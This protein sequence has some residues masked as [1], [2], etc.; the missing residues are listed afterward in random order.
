MEVA[1]A[2][3]LTRASMESEHYHYTMNV[4]YAPYGDSFAAS[5]AG[6]NLINIKKCVLLYVYSFFLSINGATDQYDFLFTIVRK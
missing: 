4:I 1:F 6:K 5:R 2:S 3:A